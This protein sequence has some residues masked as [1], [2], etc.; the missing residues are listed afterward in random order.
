LQKIKEEYGEKVKIIWKSF[1]LAPDDKPNRKVYPAAAKGWA[2]IAQ[3]EKEAHFRKWNLPLYPRSSLQALEATKCAELQGG[4]AAGQ[5]HERLMKAFFGE[6][7]DISSREELI[8]LARDAGL[9][10]D[11]FIRDYDS[12]SQKAEVV[13]DYVEA[14]RK[15]GVTGIP[16]AIFNKEYVVVGA[17]PL[18]AYKQIIDL[19]S[20][21]ES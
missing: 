4:E 18:E 19:L 2:G 9:D 7:R 14:Q 1:P 11:R 10:I 8:A 6:S 5:F 3:V 13:K 15:W 17:Q 16:T 21:S 20:Q 12:G